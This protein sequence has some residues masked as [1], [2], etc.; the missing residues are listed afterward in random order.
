MVI[1]FF[2]HIHSRSNI[3]AVKLGQD[4]EFDRLSTTG[5]LNVK[6][7]LSL[8]TFGCFSAKTN[9]PKWML[10]QM[11][12]SRKKV[13]NLQLHKVSCSTGGDLFLLVTSKVGNTSSY[14]CNK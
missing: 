11:C 7:V 4:K 9:V 5:S 13:E 3:S 8:E 2:S 12:V 10:P 1:P 14:R 6:V